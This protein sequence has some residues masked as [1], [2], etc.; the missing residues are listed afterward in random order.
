MT[1]NYD[2]TINPRDT[3]ENAYESYV[4]VEADGCDDRPRFYRLEV[5]DCYDSRHRTNRKS[6]QDLLDELG[7]TGDTEV[8]RGAPPSPKGGMYYTC[9]Y[10]LCTLELRYESHPGLC[11]GPPQ[12]TSDRCK[13]GPGHAE[14]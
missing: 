1:V 10:C 6:L 5:P 14:C 8:K 7:D 13:S 4:V 12:G 2:V 11:D 3:D 9:D